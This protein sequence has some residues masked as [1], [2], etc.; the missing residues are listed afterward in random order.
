[1]LGLG[2]GMGV[3]NG[4]GLKFVGSGPLANAPVASAANQNMW[5]MSTD[6]GLCKYVRV[7]NNAGIDYINCGRPS[8][9]IN[10][11]SPSNPYTV[12][13][14][15]LP[16]SISQA[17]VVAALSGGTA[18]TTPFNIRFYNSFVGV[19]V[20]D[21]A[22]AEIPATQ[23]NDAFNC[24]VALNTGASHMIKAGSS[25]SE[26]ILNGSGSYSGNL[27]IGGRTD[28][29]SANFEGKIA[30]ISFYQGYNPDGSF[31]GLT[32][33]DRYDFNLWDGSNSGTSIMG[34]PYTVVKGS[35]ITEAEYALVPLSL[36]T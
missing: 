29:V 32:L 28:G 24:I 31:A 2:L 8:H 33:V 22:P 18:V 9:I 14:C 17:G 25:Y 19:T 36:L 23:L 1:M 10:L 4:S 11:L 27:F 34:A 30:F 20:G 26:S 16:S 12:R 35:P 5:Y 21:A 13:V 3:G 6:F 7:F 15:L